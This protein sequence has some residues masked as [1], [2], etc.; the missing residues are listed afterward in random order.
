MPSAPTMRRSPPT[1]ATSMHASSS[2]RCFS[3]STTAPTRARCSPACCGRIRRS[4]ARSSAWR[5]CSSFDGS[6][7]ADS[8]V[9]RSLA[10]N[11]RLVD[12]R[13]MLARLRLDSEDYDDAEREAA[14]A[15]ETDPGSPGRARAD[16]GE[17]LHAGRSQRIRG[18]EPTRARAR[19][20]IG[21]RSTRRW[22]R[23]RAAT[24]DIRTPSTFARRAVAQD[25]RPRSRR[26][27]SE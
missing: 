17:P 3:R 9:K 15:L 7:G 27:R 25:P 21:R 20:S 22:P 14:R 19:S 23:S 16:R 4:R 10:V 5:A 13:L 18:R 2:A 6:P 12:A 11:A 1:R 26:A 24:G 8:L